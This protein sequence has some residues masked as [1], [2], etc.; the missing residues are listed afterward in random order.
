MTRIRQFIRWL[1][2]S[3]ISGR[4]VSK[5]YADDNPDTT[6]RERVK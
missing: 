5:R 2:R 1:F 6:T 3:A 4:F